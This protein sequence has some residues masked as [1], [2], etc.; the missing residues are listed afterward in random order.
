MFDFIYLLHTVQEQVRSRP[1]YLGCTVNFRTTRKSYKEK[2]NIINDPEKWAV[3]EGTQEPIID[4]YTYQLAQKLIGTPRRHDT[5]GEA[6]PL[7]GLVF[8][9]DCGA[10]RKSTQS[11][12]TI[13]P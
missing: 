7:T 12:S 8:C 3:F 5:L 6:N 11:A 10:K 9:A 2:K 13:C 1:E 4:A